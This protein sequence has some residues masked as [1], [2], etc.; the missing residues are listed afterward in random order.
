[1]LPV[2]AISC[3][4][5]SST[6]T[7][8][9]VPSYLSI[10]NGNVWNYELTN[11]P[12]TTPVTSSYSLTSSATDTTINSRLYHIFNRSA[13]GTKE[14]YY[15]N[16]NEYYEYLSI[17]LLGNVQFE[18]I[19][20]KSDAAAGAVWSQTIPPI[21]YSGVTA[22]L[23]KNDTIKEKGLTKVVK[24]ITYTDVVH[25]TSGLKILSVS[26]PLIPTTALTAV[27]DNY[28]APKVGRIYS[29]NNIQLVVPPP[30]SISQG[31]ENKTELV[32]TNF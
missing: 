28:Y 18:N 16:G 10:T 8:V 4:K 20:L 6:P 19:F 9:V 25:V 5:N 1:M 21:I 3:K 7:P 12:S 30:V 29:S 24:G 23:I 13:S 11:N 31:L 26:P 14:Y 17:P 32:S 2:L 27:I 22:N 15:V